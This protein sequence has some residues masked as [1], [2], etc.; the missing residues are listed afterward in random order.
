MPLPS[1]DW[2]AWTNLQE[3]ASPSTPFAGQQ[4]FVDYEAIS[5]LSFTVYT[6]YATF[7]AA[8][9]PA[10]DAVPTLR[11]AVDPF[12]GWSSQKELSGTPRPPVLGLT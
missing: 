12:A 4:A 3:L 11:N 9:L 1:S 7:T 8:G 6:N 2:R 5:N 10:W